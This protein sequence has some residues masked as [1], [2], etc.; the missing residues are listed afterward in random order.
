MTISS[1]VLRKSRF[2]QSYLFLLLYRCRYG[3]KSY[4][5]YGKSWIWISLSLLY[6]YYW[7]F[8]TLQR[9]KTHHLYSLYE[10]NSIR[11][12]YTNGSLSRIWRGGNT[13]SKIVPP[14]YNWKNIDINYEICD[15]LKEKYTFLFT[16]E[17][18][19]NIYDYTLVKCHGE[20][21]N[22]WED[23]FFFLKDMFE[24][25]VGVAPLDEQKYIYITRKGAEN[26]SLHRGKKVRSILNE[27][28]LVRAILPLG[29]DYIQLETLCF[30]DKIRLFQSSKCILA[31]NTAALM[32][33]I[34]CKKECTIIE[35]IPKY[36]V[37]QYGTHWAQNQYELMTNYLQLPYI[38]FQH[39]AYVEEQLNGVVRVDILCDTL[40]NVLHT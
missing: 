6:V 40:Q 33:C 32:F 2:V 15:L 12:R 11:C 14:N 8:T 13:S 31:P 38:R 7:R 3:R 23:A 29:F 26:I 20:L 22:K 9:D 39:Y 37:G 30:A 17:G 21:D 16:L 36:V 4:L 35:M 18:F 5:L 28:E 19:E 25:I 10:A 1:I 34:F 27:E 24:S